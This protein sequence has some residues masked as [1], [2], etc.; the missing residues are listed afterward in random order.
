MAKDEEVLINEKGTRRQLEKFCLAV[1]IIAAIGL[2]IGLI[3]YLA[4]NA[5][6]DTSDYVI[7]QP[8]YPTSSKYAIDNGEK[9]MIDNQKTAMGWMDNQNADAML[10]LRLGIMSKYQPGRCDFNTLSKSLEF[11]ILSAL[12]RSKTLDEITWVRMLLPK[13]IVALRAACMD[14]TNFHGHNLIM[15][16]EDHFSKYTQYYNNTRTS[17]AMLLLAKCVSE[18]MPAK[19]HLEALDMDRDFTTV[20]E[21][22]LVL[23]ALSCLNRTNYYSTIMKAENYLLTKFNNSNFG[24]TYETGLAAQALSKSNRTEVESA[25]AEAVLYLTKEI[26]SK[27]KGKFL[28]IGEASNVLPALAMMSWAD[29]KG[30]CPNLRVASVDTG[31]KIVNVTI[32]IDGG[33]IFTGVDQTFPSVTINEG[34]SLLV[35]LE[36]LQRTNSNFQ[37]TSSSTAYGTILNSVMGKQVAIGSTQS[38]NIHLSGS[39][40]MQGMYLENIIPADGSRYILKAE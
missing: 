18:S 3:A 8:D 1:V 34:Q 19:D 26:Q 23:M 13:Y 28:N 25:V 38:W 24:S 37:F 15:I 32:Q 35:A 9:W 7:T 6:G 30:K 17:A 36:T 12:L 4:T 22:S 40:N 10:A 33:D 31:P 2:I 16:L 27:R 14:A 29:V 5:P 20:T 39:A 11:D 21:A